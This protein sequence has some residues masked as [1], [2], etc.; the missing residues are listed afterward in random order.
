MRAS[1]DPAP[2]AK[3]VS[4]APSPMRRVATYLALLAAVVGGGVLLAWLLVRQPSAAGSV[5]AEA[6]DPTAANAAGAAP[7]NTVLPKPEPKTIT[8]TSAAKAE[9]PAQ[10]DEIAPAAPAEPAQTEPEAPAR[11]RSKRPPRTSVPP[12]EPASAPTGEPEKPTSAP[13]S[14]GER[15][16]L[17]MRLQ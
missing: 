15:N 2:E 8:T 16:P 13:I 14:P 5:A 1:A 10:P 17:H 6:V 12:P 9:A 4:Q 7:V 11:T 3:R